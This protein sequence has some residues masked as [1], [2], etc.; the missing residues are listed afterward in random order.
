MTV[1]AVALDFDGVV[2]ESVE[3]K[4]RAFGELFRDDHPDKVDEIVRFQLANIGLSRLA[5]FPRIYEEI[6]EIPFPEGELERLDQRF[7]QIVYEAVVGCPYVPGAR[8]LLEGNGGD[9]AFF[10][11]SATPEW[12]LRRIVEARGLAP[13]FRAVYGAPDKKPEL[14][15]RILADEGLDPDALLFVGDAENDFAAA[16]ETGVAFVGRVPKGAP[17]PFPPE[18]AV[19]SDLAEL[20]SMLRGVD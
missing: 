10:V 20:A 19:V 16:R 18:Q 13:F 5:K 8:E 9:H 3:L 7:S 12:E 6:L 17:S 14:L 1:E 15:R 2:V 11:V 4:N